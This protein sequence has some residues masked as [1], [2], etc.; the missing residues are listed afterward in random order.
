M[1]SPMRIEG[2]I[3]AIVPMHDDRRPPMRESGA[4]PERRGFRGARE[5]K[6]GLSLK[7]YR[8]D[9]ELENCSADGDLI[10]P[11]QEATFPCRR[12]ADGGLT[13]RGPWACVALG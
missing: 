4:P 3:L 11:L 8:K 1:Q 12:T 7:G 10:P 9:E 5:L 2:S 6:K 13:R